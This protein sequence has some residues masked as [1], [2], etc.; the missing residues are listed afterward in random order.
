MFHPFSNY[1]DFTTE[2]V[3]INYLTETE[4][5]E[6]ASSGLKHNKS[7]EKQVISKINSEF[8]KLSGKKYHEFR[9]VRNKYDKI[10]VVKTQPNNIK[11][12]LDLVDTWDEQRGEKY[13]WQRHSGY[14]RNFFENVYPTAKNDLFCYFFYIEDKCV[15]YSVISKL[16]DGSNFN[17]V[18]RK[19]NT[20]HRNL[21]LYV[22]LK[23]FILMMDE[24]KNEFFINWGSSGRGVLKYK[25][26]FPLHSEEVVYFCKLLKEENNV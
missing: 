24:I 1:K 19:N 2:K 6:L 16:G 5:Q 26:K 8:L 7:K 17:Y 9:E 3:F 21:C 12:V 25:K 23:S 20:A 15:G 22:D 14:D 4:Y 13:G 18:I 10:V 11:D